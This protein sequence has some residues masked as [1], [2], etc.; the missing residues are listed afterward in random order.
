MHER[1]TLSDSSK[2]NCEVEVDDFKSE[3]FMDQ[4]VNCE[5]IRSVA[6]IQHLGKPFS[7]RYLEK[8][9]LL[10][11]LY[12]HNHS[13]ISSK[14]CI[15]TFSKI[16]VEKTSFRW[17]LTRNFNAPL[18]ES[19]CPMPQ[20]AGTQLAGTQLHRFSCILKFILMR[21]YAIQSTEA[22]KSSKNICQFS[23]SIPNAPISRYTSDG[24]WRSHRLV[25][26]RKNFN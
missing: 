2:I 3:L 25:N 7:S 4:A 18:K 26:K 22:I 20:L 9:S 17:F 8:F 5:A 16:K 6:F 24:R 15:G 21:F 14:G 19:H 12:L 11:S 1:M 10:E 13:E 23:N